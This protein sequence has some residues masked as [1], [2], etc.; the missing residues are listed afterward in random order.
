MAHTSPQKIA[1]DNQVTSDPSSVE[2]IG[3][4]AQFKL[5]GHSFADPRPSCRLRRG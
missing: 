1:Q 5:R 3:S 2:I 4:G